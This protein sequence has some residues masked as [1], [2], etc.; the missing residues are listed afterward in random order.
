MSR[1]SPL[2]PPDEELCIVALHKRRSPTSS[3]QAPTN[4]P[5]LAFT[6]MGDSKSIPPS[7]RVLYG[8]RIVADF[9]ARLG[10][11][12]TTTPVP[13]LS[14]RPRILPSSSG[15]QE[16][17]PPVSEMVGIIGGG[18]A[19]LYAAML[20]KDMEV[21]YRILEAGDRFGGRMY[22]YKFLTGRKY[23]YYVM[24]KYTILCPSAN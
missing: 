22:T 3:S 1:G 4:H 15:M 13:E 23:D 20:L 21:P 9:H 2:L 11:S 17:L 8:K 16:D 14:K 24:S 5:N 18:A 10:Q 6:I 7:A 12:H 19:G